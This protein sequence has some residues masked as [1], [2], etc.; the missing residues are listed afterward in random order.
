V[1][2]ELARRLTRCFREILGV[3]AGSQGDGQLVGFESGPVSCLGTDRHQRA[4][5]AVVATL[6]QADQEVAV[7]IGLFHVELTLRGPRL[8]VWI[9]LHRAPPDD[10]DTSR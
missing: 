8:R 6:E 2:S 1:G 3:V 4:V 7:C 10:S 9:F 5:G